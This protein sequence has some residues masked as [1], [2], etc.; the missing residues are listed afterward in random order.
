MEN[1]KTTEV[2][3]AL[4][5][6]SEAKGGFKTGGKYEE[7]VGELETREP[8]IQILGQDWDTSLPAVW[9][10]IKEIQED[11]KALKRHKA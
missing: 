11:L 3:D 4:S 9:E 2:I 7:L 6:C 1:R 5:S 8:L 10:V